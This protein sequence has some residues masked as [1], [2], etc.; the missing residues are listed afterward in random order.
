VENLSAVFPNGN[1]GLKALDK[2]SFMVYPREFVCVLG[3]SGGGKSTLLRI[4]SGLIPASDGVVYY[5]GSPVHAPQ[6]GIGIVFQ[7]ANLMPWRSVIDNILLPLELSGLPKVEARK[8]GEELIDLVGLRG[9]ENS[10]PN[11][12]SGGMEQRVAI[13]RALIHDPEL[14]LL[15]E[16][17]GAL[18]ALTREKM[19]YEL[20]KIWH[21]RQK[22]VIMVTHSISEAIY[23]SDR[24]MVLSNRP[25][26]IRLDIEVKLSRPRD[27]WSR[28]DQRYM[29]VAQSVRAQIE[30]S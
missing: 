1:G 9:F 16:P 28:Y 26:R 19:G 22:T 10:F 11:E 12:L 29:E 24:I 30:D 25:G 18:D 4:L 14:L 3:P 17:F 20:M 21:A 2:L 27:E 5:Q 6:S 13:A 8:M 23:L 15:D 7:K